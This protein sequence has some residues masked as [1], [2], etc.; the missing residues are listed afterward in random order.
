MWLAGFERLLGMMACGGCS[1]CM[2]DFK[3]LAVERRER[4]GV[5]VVRSSCV[6]I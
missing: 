3:R 5:G 4:L 1:S 2:A 6:D